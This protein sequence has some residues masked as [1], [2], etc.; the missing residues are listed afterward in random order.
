[1]K[2]TQGVYFGLLSVQNI[3][4]QSTRGGGGGGAFVFNLST[5]IY[6]SLDALDFFL[7][8][9][10]SYIPERNVLVCMTYIL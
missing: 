6:L 4:R 8:I 1:M 2:I 9:F 7:S 10:S 3:N 5:Y